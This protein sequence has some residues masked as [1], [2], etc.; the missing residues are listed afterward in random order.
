MAVRC[1][2]S[3]HAYETLQRRGYDEAGVLLVTC[4]C[5]SDYAGSSGHRQAQCLIGGWRNCYL[6]RGARVRA[7]SSPL[8]LSVG[9]C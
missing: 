4:Y 8:A 9:A 7:E 2:C 1:A 3:C 6:G 5:M